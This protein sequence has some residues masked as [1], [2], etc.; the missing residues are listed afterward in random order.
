MYTVSS[1]LGR[2]CPRTCVVG[3]LSCDWPLLHVAC[4]GASCAAAGSHD[5]ASPLIRRS[6]KSHIEGFQVTPNSLTVHYDFAKIS[7]AQAQL[8]GSLPF[9]EDEHGWALD[10]GFFLARWSS[11]V[12]AAL[13]HPGAKWESAE[14]PANRLKSALTS[15]GGI[16]FEL[17]TFRNESLTADN[18]KQL[19]D[20]SLIHI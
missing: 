16:R 2:S 17:P 10:I 9:D 13:S 18:I 7:M 11:A 4:G 12:F 14:K 20:L 8:L 15:T 6:L 3:G 19:L 1:V 5:S